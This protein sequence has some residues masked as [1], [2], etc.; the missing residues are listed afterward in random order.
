MRNLK[1]LFVFSL[2]SSA[3]LFTS[4][5]KAENLNV[6]YTKTGLEIAPNQEVPQ[7]NSPARG[8]MV[9]SYNKDLKVLTFNVDYTGLTGAPIG[10]H[11]HGTAARGVNAPIRFDFTQFIPKTTSGNVQRA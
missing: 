11:I 3:A 8:I 9:V 7:N 1:L 2:V 6:V 5:K 10:S 4:C